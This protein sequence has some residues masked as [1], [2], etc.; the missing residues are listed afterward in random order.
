MKRIEIPRIDTTGILGQEYT[1]PDEVRDRLP[2]TPD[3]IEEARQQCVHEFLENFL[4]PRTYLDSELTV[5]E[6]KAA[7][8][9]HKQQFRDVHPN[10]FDGN[11]EI[12]TQ[13][14]LKL[15]ELYVYLNRSQSP[16]DQKLTETIKASLAQ[17]KPL[18]DEHLEELIEI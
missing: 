4:L 16:E 15:V 11:Y 1:V 10:D 2:M 13:A 17:L 18:L 8:I 6:L 14:E 9:Q 7:A 5:D 3:H 12:I